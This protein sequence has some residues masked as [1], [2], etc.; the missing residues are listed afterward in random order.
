MAVTEVIAAAGTLPGEGEDSRCEGR[1]ELRLVYC[2]SRTLSP[3]VIQFL[4]PFQG[5]PFRTDA[6]FPEDPQ[7]QVYCLGYVAGTSDVLNLTRSVCT[8]EGIH[9]SQ[10]LNVIVNYL[11]AH[12]EGR[13]GPVSLLAGLALREAFPCKNPVR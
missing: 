7:K 12:P 10:T 2:G 4:S 13:D 5:K 1:S 9:T 11:R 6:T 8:P 3:K